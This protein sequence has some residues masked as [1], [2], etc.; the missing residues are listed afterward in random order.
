MAVPRVLEALGCRVEEL[1]E[2][3]NRRFVFAPLDGAARPKE[4]SPGSPQ[5]LHSCR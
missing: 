2:F 5:V 1:P 4:P 3:G